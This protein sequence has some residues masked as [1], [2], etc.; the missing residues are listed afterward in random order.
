MAQEKQNLKDALRKL[1]GLVTDLE[2]KDVDV[3]AGLAKFREGV[4]LV[5]FCQSQL[6][7]SEN[8]FKRLKEELES[9]EEEIE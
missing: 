7:E 5:K 3:E 9:E 8:E 6:K 4:E 1:E 2:Q